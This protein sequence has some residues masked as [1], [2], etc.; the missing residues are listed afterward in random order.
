MQIELPNIIKDLFNQV[1]YKGVHENYYKTLFIFSIRKK[2]ILNSMQTK[3]PEI[4]EN[5]SEEGLT[6]EDYKIKLFKL[7]ENK[8]K[9]DSKAIENQIESLNTEIK[10]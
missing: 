6:S 3:L 7:I 1:L 8:E 5:L 2:D 4:L 10:M 9:Y